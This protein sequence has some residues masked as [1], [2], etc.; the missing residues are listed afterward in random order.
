[1]YNKTLAWSL[2]LVKR[3]KLKELGYVACCDHKIVYV[4][5][6]QKC[7]AVLVITH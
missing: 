5:L 3:T 6:Y 7:W 1:M 2:F 4:P